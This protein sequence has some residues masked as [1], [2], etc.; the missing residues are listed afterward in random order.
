M[1]E[2]NKISVIVPVYNAEE[3]LERCIHS[4]IDQT[5]ENWELLLVD[6][7]S[8]DQSGI[9]C[10]RYG[11]KDTRIRVIHQK[12][13]G[14]SVARNKGIQSATGD[15][16]VFLD[17]DDWLEIDIL[18][19]ILPNMDATT[20]FLLFDYYEITETRKC[21]KKIFKNRTEIAFEKDTEYT[22]ELLLEAFAGHYTEYTINRPLIGGV[23]GKAYKRSKIIESGIEFPE[24]VSIC[25]DML[26]NICYCSLCEKIVYESI[27]LYNYYINENSASHLMIEDKWDNFISGIHNASLA[28]ML[29]KDQ[30]LSESG[31][32]ISEYFQLYLIQIVLWRLPNIHNDLNIQKGELFC[33]EQAKT[34]GMLPNLTIIEKSIIRCCKRGKI[35]GLRVCLEIINYA[36]KNE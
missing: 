15:Y 31:Q 1:K 2:K 21:E 23:W 22:K 5:Y 19:Y 9:M 27:A 4:V 34:I 14:V 3:Y 17:A 11:E 10:D 35:T 24:D 12:N 26:F 13:A 7:G 33:I 6:D 36:K 30:L 8:I 28:V 18:D 25:E 20:D 29:A 32:L 16:V